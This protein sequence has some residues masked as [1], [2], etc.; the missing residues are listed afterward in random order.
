[1]SQN[2]PLLLRCR[3]ALPWSH[4][5]FLA[6]GL[7][8]IACLSAAD[9][10]PELAALGLPWLWL[11]AVTSVCRWPRRWLAWLP[12]VCALATGQLLRELQLTRL[13]PLRSCLMRDGPCTVNAVAH[14]QVWQRGG[15]LDPNRA[16]ATVQRLHWPT[17]RSGPQAQGV[18]LE[19]VLP[20][21]EPLRQPGLYLL[22]GDLSLPPP[23]LNPASFD[24][25]QH[26]LRQGW[27]ASLQATSLQQISP[28]G[29]LAK[30]QF[31]L[32]T[33][34]QQGRDGLRRILG[35]GLED[36]IQARSVILAMALG[37]SAQAGPQA[38]WAFRN[39]GTLHVFAVSGLH[40]ALLA[41]FGAALIHLLGLGRW[42]WQI[43]LV[44]V[45][46]YAWM[47][48]WRPSAAR[49]AIMIA[50]VLLAPLAMRR[51]DLQNSLGFAATLLLLCS[52]QTLFSPGFQLSFA[53][54]WA[55][56]VIAPALMK[57]CEPWTQPD[58]LVPRQLISMAQR[59]RIA[60]TRHCCQL[61]STS[62]AAWL[63]SLPLLWGHF[64]SITPVGLAAN[65][66]LVP[67]SSLGMG[68]T[69]LCVMSAA[70]G[71]EAL[72]CCNGLNARV[73][74]A[75]LQ[76]ADAFAR[77]PGSNLT[78]DLRPPSQR[79]I[80][81]LQWL[82]LPRG[83]SACL[84]KHRNCRWLL[85][86]GSST[87]WNRE[88]APML[89]LEG[90]NQL[91]GL[92]LTHADARH[93]GA[94]VQ[95]SQWGR[96]LIHSSCAE[97]HAKD[98]P[99]TALRQLAQ[100]I[101]PDSSR[102]HRH[103][104]EQRLSIAEDC[105]VEILHPYRSDRA[106]LAD[107]RTMVFR[108][109]IGELRVLWLGDAGF[110]TE[111]LLLERHR[112]L[113]CD[114][115]VCGHHPEDPGGLPD[116]LHRANPR[117]IVLAA[118]PQEQQNDPSARLRRSARELGVPLWDLQREGCVTLSQWPEGWRLVGFCSQRTM[119]LPSGGGPT[120]RLQKAPSAPR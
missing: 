91:D 28:A 51:S 58:N 7:L 106:A 55:I 20:G 57:P 41:I 70:L 17:R 88:V 118:D 48:G 16:L 49:A 63:G 110:A 100:L 82:A 71:P 99:R 73:A 90:V 22:R 19:V 108:I 84:M 98:S 18:Q 13:H 14:L 3:H 40:V 60:L 112:D 96:P 85:D 103:H 31:S 67:L 12:L 8:L 102:W 4:R 79:P 36:Q 29:Q 116:L 69:L 59:A 62:V 37:D 23:P 89:N 114:L 95:A 11:V 72:T 94:A 64:R 25:P 117:A 32:E 120:Q 75:M 74:Q 77:V 34:A 10:W 104:A 93:V 53:V 109:Q 30:L 50:L 66:L 39:S 78:L 113:R 54:L 1:M 33:L 9:R 26:A 61:A 76:S 2:T 46:G 42:R 97:P 68:L 119:D 80:S 92:L 5:P 47:T 21:S 101:A 43:L 86:C 38:L 27:V 107:D 45:L 52:P 111:C 81:Q 44:L 115:M 24:A 65:M 15:Q 56:A 35:L 87:D 105:A 6:L 83:G